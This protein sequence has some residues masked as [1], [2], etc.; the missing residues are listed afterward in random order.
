MTNDTP[1]QIHDIDGDGKNEVVAVRDFELQILD[2]RTGEVRSRAWMPKPPA[3]DK[4][5]PY[6]METGDSIS[7]VNF[8]G[9]LARHEILVKDRYTHFWVYNNKLQ[10]L[11]KGDGQTGH[12]P[13]PVDARATGR[14]LLM[15]GY[16]LWDHTGK[17][18]WSH[19]KDLKDHA[20]G[21]MVGNLSGDAKAEPRV[22]ASGSD[23]SDVAV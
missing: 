4:D 10:L 8:S 17:Q 13:Y 11:W 5:R 19:D 14:D 18:L 1:F 6:E 22:Y 9:N 23:D 15:I 3:A 20:D 2:G 16:A 12:Y 21:V 7:F